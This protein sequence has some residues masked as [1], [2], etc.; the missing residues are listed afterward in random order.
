MIITDSN[1]IF[2]QKVPA[3]TID[4]I[5]S[6]NWLVKFNEMRGGFYLEKTIP[7]EMPET[8]YGNCI[9]RADKITRAFN[10]WDGSL[11]VLLCGFKGTGKS[12]LAKKICLDMD[13]PVL[14]V[15]EPYGGSEFVSFLSKIPQ[16]AIIL[17]DE[18]E[19]VYKSGMSESQ[20][21]LLSILDGVFSSK[22][23]FYLGIA[24]S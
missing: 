6:G 16:K 4:E 5:P 11:G 22:F 21:K 20:E 24:V 18:F 14:V 19:K 3:K 2:L 13:I 12:L 9:E 17:F 7:F 15:S 1:E 23:P 10:T 8:I